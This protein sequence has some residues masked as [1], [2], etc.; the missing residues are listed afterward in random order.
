MDIHVY[1]ESEFHS[2]EW[3]GGKTTEMYISPHFSSYEKRNFAVR[4]S[5]ATVELEQSVFTQLTGIDRLLILLD[6]SIT[7]QHN[8][9]PVSVLKP[10][11]PHKFRG[12]ERTE[13]RGLCRD[14]NVM[15]QRE[16]CRIVTCHVCQEESF[17]LPVQED[18]CAFLYTVNGKYRIKTPEGEWMPVCS[19]ELAEVYKNDGM[20]FVQADQPGQVIFVSVQRL[21]GRK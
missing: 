20:V 14:F 18:E 16:S 1:R 9:G 7:I 11:S 19:G 13:S 10:F 6:G 8:K 4:I 17:H 21:S 15:V 3:S 12:E 5:T 2:V